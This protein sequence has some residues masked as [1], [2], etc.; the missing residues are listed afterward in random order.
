MARVFVNVRTSKEDIAWP[1]TIAGVVSARSGLMNQLRFGFGCD[2][3]GALPCVECGI[4]VCEVNVQ[5]NS[6]VN[7]TDLLVGKP[8]LSQG[9]FRVRLDYPDDSIGMIIS[10]ETELTARIG[11]NLGT[12]RT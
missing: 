6:P 8:L 7:S 1:G 4:N 9:T 3:F 11:T 5:Y 2:E 10:D 12:D